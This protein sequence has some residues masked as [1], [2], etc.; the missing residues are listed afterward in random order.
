M[1]EETKLIFFLLGTSKMRICEFGVNNSDTVN[2]RTVWCDLYHSRIIEIY[3]IQNNENH[4]K[5][6]RAII[7]DVFDRQKSKNF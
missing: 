7:T 4:Y 1:S 5:I 2:I 3:F 6:V